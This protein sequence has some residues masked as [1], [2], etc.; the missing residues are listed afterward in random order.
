MFV[1]E[2]ENGIVFYAVQ[3]RRVVGHI[4]VRPRFVW[5]IHVEIRLPIGQIKT[6]V[7]DEFD[8]DFVGLG[9][10]YV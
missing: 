5:K 1:R 10:D 2:Q 7:A 8:F 3:F 9:K 6:G 4:L